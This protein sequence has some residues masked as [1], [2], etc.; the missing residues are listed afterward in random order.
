MFEVSDFPLFKSLTVSAAA[1]LLPF[2]IPYSPTLC[3]GLASADL[4]LRTKPALYSLTCRVPCLCI[5]LT[6][7]GEDNN[8]TTLLHN[9]TS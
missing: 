1:C 6:C 4:E 2:T 5:A 7:G 3:L 9:V 8:H